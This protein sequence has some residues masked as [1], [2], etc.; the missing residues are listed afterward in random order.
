MA[1]N[2]KV[3]NITLLVSLLISGYTIWLSQRDVEIVAVHCQG[4]FSDILV[5]NFPV[6]DRAKIQWWIKNKALLNEKYKIPTP[7]KDGFF[8]VTF[9]SFGEGYKEKEKYDRLCFSD[10]KQ[11]E[12]CIEKDAVFSV[13][14]SKNRGVIFTVYD[15]KYYTEKN[16]TTVKVRGNYSR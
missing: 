3:I 14:H 13:S 5:N 12:N 8:S 10:M 4:E 9:W 16:G 11:K 15:G 2:K 1:K 7:A 6:T